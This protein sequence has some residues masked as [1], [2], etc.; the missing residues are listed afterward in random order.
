MSLPTSTHHKVSLVGLLTVLT[1]NYLVTSPWSNDASTDLASTTSNSSALDFDRD[2]KSP[3]S[4]GAAVFESN[5]ERQRLADDSNDE[6]GS[7]EV[8]LRTGVAAKPKTC[9]EYAGADSGRMRECLEKL[10][11]RSSPNTKTAAEE[12]IKK[13][14]TPTDIRVTEV[15]IS[16]DAKTEGM[17]C[18]DAGACRA[19]TWTFVVESDDAAAIVEAVRVA[20]QERAEDMLAE[21]TCEFEGTKTELRECRERRLKE[22]ARECRNERRTRPVARG[23]KLPWILNARR[24]ERGESSACEQAKSMYKELQ[25]DLIALTK[26]DPEAARESA[27]ALHRSVGTISAL[28]DVA[29]G[30]SA[31]SLAAEIRVDQRQAIEQLA[32]LTDWQRANPEVVRQL[33]TATADYSRRYQEVLRSGSRSA[34]NQDAIALAG[35]QSLEPFERV[36]CFGLYR[37]QGPQAMRPGFCSPLRNNVQDPYSGLAAA[38][39]LLHG[40]HQTVLTDD[41]RSTYDELFPLALRNRDTQNSRLFQGPPNFLDY[42]EFFLTSS[43]V[44]GLSRSTI[45]ATRERFNSP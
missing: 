45:Q 20:Y 7:I 31:I 35:P 10:N 22:L 44:T 39:E 13:N 37:V 1:L 24:S 12:W 28:S 15:T 43:P 8:G 17:F 19:R 5:Q 16:G 14:L 32:N 38:D 9:T 27:L 34:L 6:V 30:L 11:E 26:S 40:S 36:T 18:P 33:L 21:K 29:T 41:S 25:K 2:F 23:H 3:N 42:N 4:F